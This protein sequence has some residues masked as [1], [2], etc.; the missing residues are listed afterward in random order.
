MKDEWAW[1]IAKVELKMRSQ[2]NKWLF[3]VGRLVLYKYVLESILVYWASLTW[4]PK[5]NLNKIKKIS[6]RY[7]WVSQ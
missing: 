4:I 5:G 7:L 2:C 3:R 1:F 6:L